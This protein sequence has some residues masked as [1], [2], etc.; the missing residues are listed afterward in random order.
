MQNTYR[1]HR[2]MGKDPD[3]ELLHKAAAMD[4]I[5]IEIKKLEQRL[6]DIRA[7]RKKAE[8]PEETVE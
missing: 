4:D 1:I 8:Q 7:E 6:M 2:A 3:D 5:I